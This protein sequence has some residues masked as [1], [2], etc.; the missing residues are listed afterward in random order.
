[1]SKKDHRRRNDFPSERVTIML[2][3]EIDAQLKFDLAREIEMCAKN[4]CKLPSTS[5]SRVINIALHKAIEKGI[6]KKIIA[7]AIKENGK[8]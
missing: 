4:K 5:Y 3:D 1:M 6:D 8:K 7:D 2:D